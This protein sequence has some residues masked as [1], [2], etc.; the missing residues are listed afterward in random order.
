MLQRRRGTIKR[1]INKIRRNRS[2]QDLAGNAP[3]WVAKSRPRPF[4]PYSDV[5]PQGMR[6]L[7]FCRHYQR[8]VVRFP[9]TSV[10]QFTA[11]LVLRQLLAGLPLSRGSSGDSRGEGSSRRTENRIRTDSNRIQ[12]QELISRA[13]QGSFAACHNGRF[14]L[15]RK[16]RSGPRSCCS[17]APRRRG[18]LHSHC[19]SQMLR[20]LRPMPLNAKPRRGVC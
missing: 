17:R 11:A 9:R 15:T 8:E 7:C 5:Y 20:L 19:L 13:R 16:T 14:L 12:M 6:S 3:W 10:E 18:A 4:Q 2:S 1:A